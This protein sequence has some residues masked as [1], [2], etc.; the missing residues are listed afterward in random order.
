MTTERTNA[1]QD[2]FRRAQAILGVSPAMLPVERYWR[3]HDGVLSEVESFARDWF[4]RRHEAARAALSAAGRIRTEGHAN[5]PEAAMRA[6]AEWQSGEA[7]RLA[8]DIDSWRRLCARCADRMTAETS[9]ADSAE[10][11]GQGAARNGGAGARLEESVT[12]E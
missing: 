2:M 11:A 5:D 12:G 1:A 8:R 10:T 4:D 9:G 3:A 7:A 6:I